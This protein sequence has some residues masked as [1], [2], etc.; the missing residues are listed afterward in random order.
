MAGMTRADIIALGIKWAGRK[1]QNIDLVEEYNFVIQDMSRRKPL[2]RAKK[3]ATLTADQN[4]LDLPTDYRS[5]DLFSPYGYLTAFK[6][7][8]NW[9]PW[10]KNPLDFWEL[11]QTQYGDPCWY[12][13]FEDPETY[14]IYF[15]PKYET[16]TPA[17][18]FL[19][20]KIH[21]KSPDAEDTYLHKYGEKWDEVVAHGVAWRAAKAIEEKDIVSREF[22][23]YEMG[24][25]EMFNLIKPVRYARTKYH[26]F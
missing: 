15:C 3:D 5:Q 13:V 14:K 26:H 7:G 21:E 11:D 6:V 10:L 23:F 18:S 25:N 2:L 8:E 1:G 17:Y 19:Y 9:I 4:Y 20:H 24:L 16:A 22:G 12:A